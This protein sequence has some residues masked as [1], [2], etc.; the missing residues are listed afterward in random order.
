MQ[1][2]SDRIADSSLHGSCAKLAVAYALKGTSQ[3][4]RIPTTPRRSKGLVVGAQ[5]R[6]AAALATTKAASLTVPFEKR[7]MS[8]GGNRFDA[9]GA[10]V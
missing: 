5:A 6:R 7:V 4:N 8:M 1:G 2:L 3:A 10:G 9:T